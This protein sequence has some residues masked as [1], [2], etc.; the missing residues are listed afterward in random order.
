M[1]NNEEM[2]VEDR[3]KKLEQA[4]E[5]NRN[6]IKRNGRSEIVLWVFNAVVLGAIAWHLITFIDHI[7]DTE[8]HET[9]EQRR[10]GMKV[11][12]EEAIQDKLPKAEV[13]LQ[14]AQHE[15]DLRELR[16][17]YAKISEALARIESKLDR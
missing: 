3:L 8:K 1:E 10:N 9:L 5:E 17:K 13:K 16:S 4:H 15:E 7:S 11:V 14:L 6:G 2:T 12:I